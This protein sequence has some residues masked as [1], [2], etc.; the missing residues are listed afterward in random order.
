MSIDTLVQYFETLSP[1]SV[2]TLH[3][4]YTEDAYFR[5]PFNEVRGVGEISGI[6]NRMF[7]NLIDPRFVVTNRIV[8]ADQA[9]LEWDFHFRIRRFRP[10]RSWTIHGTSHVCLTPEGRVHYHRDYWDSGAE[11]YAKLP[12]VGAAVR[13]LARRMA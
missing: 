11:L 5:D 3:R 7:E 4:H 10:D 9:M 8:Q 1:E 6:F 12:V 2:S 13:W